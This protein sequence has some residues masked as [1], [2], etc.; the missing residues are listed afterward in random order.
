MKNDV[1]EDLYFRYHKEILLYL[2]SLCGNRQLSEDLCQDTFV[3]ALL[4]L[5]DKHKNVR[6]WLYL[7]ARNLFLNSS[8]NLKR[9]TSQEEICE[10]S[11]D[12]DTLD[13]MITAEKSKLLYR[14]MQKLAPKKR[15]ILVLQYWGELS[16]KEIA[17]VLQI[18]PENV[19]V[20]GHRGKKDLKKILEEYGYEI[21]RND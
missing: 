19:R 12:D 21:Y 2:Y 14:A 3:K 20:L 9:E 15:E 4:S 7:V 5:S 16:Q 10:Q 13:N 18:T 11:V 8:R 17:A 6:A 1:L